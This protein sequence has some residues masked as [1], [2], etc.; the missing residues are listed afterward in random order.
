M[1]FRFKSEVNIWR[2]RCSQWQ[3]G[4]LRMLPSTTEWQ[5]QISFKTICQSLKKYWTTMS[6][7]LKA[8]IY[9]QLVICELFSFSFSIKLRV[10]FLFLNPKLT[11]KCYVFIANFLFFL[12]FYAELFYFDFSMTKHLIIIRSLWKFCLTL[13]HNFLHLFSVSPFIFQMFPKKSPSY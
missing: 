5:L 8:E 9:L 10:N 7:I 4:W 2:A 11:K 6:K 3:M 13:S 12:F 1:R